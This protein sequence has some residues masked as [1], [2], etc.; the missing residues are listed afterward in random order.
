MT[1]MEIN[2][3]YK[4]ED[5]DFKAAAKVTSKRVVPGALK[6][7]VALLVLYAALYVLGTV[8]E[9]DLRFS[10]GFVLGLFAMTLCGALSY[11]I[12]VAKNWKALPAMH[13]ANRVVATPEGIMQD[14][15][16]AHTRYLW[17]HFQGYVEEK[18][19]FFVL[20]GKHP[21]LWFP[22]RV[23]APGDEERIRTLLQEK[24]PNANK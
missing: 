3:E 4:L 20:M 23:L 24:L 8:V 17:T 15:D 10:S 19:H 22:K 11:H 21:V 2:F 9:T 14:G 5:A 6:N 13:Q 12:Q 7:L 18:S 1:N 16:T